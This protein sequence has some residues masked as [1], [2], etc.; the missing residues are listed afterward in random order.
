MILG[1]DDGVRVEEK[2]IFCCDEDDRDGAYTGML[3][4]TK[5]WI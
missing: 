1:R 3:I 2:G 5:Y 4:Y